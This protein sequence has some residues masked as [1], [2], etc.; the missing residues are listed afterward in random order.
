MVEEKFALITGAGSG[1]G[2]ELAR[3]LIRRKSNVA[4]TDINGERLDEVAHELEKNKP[5]S[6]Q[7][8]EKFCLDHTKH[9]ENVAL[10]KKYFGKFP[11]IDILCLNAGIGLGGDFL[12]HKLSDFHKL[13]DVNYFSNISLLHSFLIHMQRQKS[14]KILFTASIAGLL[15]LPM[16]SAYS[17]SKF[18]VVGLAESIRAELANDQISVSVLCP[19]L[20]KTNI[21]N[22]SALRTTKEGDSTAKSNALEVYAKYGASAKQI[23]KDGINGMLKNQDIITS[24]LSATLMHSV[25]RASPTI[26]SMANQ[27]FANLSDKKLN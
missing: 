19:G 10:E 1:I 16:L 9:E 17:A 4:L 15:G 18:A 25:K 6:S 21:A 24:P 27:F 8:I 5:K 26:F 12:N 22:D 2:K 13:M 20:V 11:R 3:E 23:A 7:R 14:G